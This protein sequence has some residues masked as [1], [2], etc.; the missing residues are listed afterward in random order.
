MRGI[1]EVV[2]RFFELVEAEGRA[3]RKSSISVVESML[4]LFFGFALMFFGLLVAGI[5]LYLWLAALIGRAGAALAVAALLFAIGAFLC[6]KAHKNAQRGE[7]FLMKEEEKL[8]A[9][10]QKSNDYGD[11]YVERPE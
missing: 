7:S 1:S 2:L 11:T 4:V 3:F 6:V 9:V 8:P 10:P 5:S